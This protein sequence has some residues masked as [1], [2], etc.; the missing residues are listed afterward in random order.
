MYEDMQAQ[1]RRAGR[2]ETLIQEVEEFTDA[3]TRTV[4]G[5]LVQSLLDMYGE[6]LARMLELMAQA[7]A[8]GH[9]LIETLANDDLVSSLLLLHGLHPI[10]I[11]T[12]IV[13]ALDGVRPYLKSH[14]G[15]VE[16]VGVEDGVA[17]LRLEGSC[18][19]CPS[20]TMTLKLTI[21]EAIYK[22][23][24][25]LDRLEVEGVA[26]PPRQPGRTGVPVTFVPSRRKKDDVNT[27]S[28]EQDNGWNTVVGLEALPAG[29]LKAITVAQE[30]LIFC[31]I[32]STYYAYYNRCASC[33]APLEDSRLDGTI[34]ACASC[35]QQYDVYRA[36]RSVDASAFFLEPIPLLV[37]DGKVKIAPGDSA[38]LSA[39]VG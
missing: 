26:D 28:Q 13:Q 27:S 9:K 34:L 5:E 39:R 18:H 4:T 1:Q 6:G 38:V 24:P 11:E 23:A 33:Q 2:I 12:R 31:R 16:F 32:E 7:G 37:E 8:P 3:H 19:G 25:D 29:T 15:N 21:E 22:A 17:S 10:D 35:G 14:G 36:G 30:P 20:S